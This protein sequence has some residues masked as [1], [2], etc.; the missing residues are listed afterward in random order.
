M[1]V[2]VLVPVPGPA[3]DPSSRCAVLE[4][5]M[6]HG[7]CLTIC[8]C[9]RFACLY[10]PLEPA[11]PPSA[12]GELCS[13]FLHHLFT[14]LNSMLTELVASLEVGCSGS[15]CGIGNPGLAARRGSCMAAGGMHHRRA[16]SMHRHLANTTCSSYCRGLGGSWPA[17]TTSMHAHIRATRLPP[18]AAGPGQQ[19]DAR[20][21]RPLPPAAAP[22][23]L[24]R[25]LHP[26]PAAHPGAHGR[27]A[28]AG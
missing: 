23:H 11:T 2:P 21:R 19:L 10:A 7:G 24:Y 4:S 3:P 5:C 26:G 14:H 18:P 27:Q 8:R 17:C 28:R 1:P 20:R 6:A 15:G 22:A 25:R 13:R 12:D 9:L 16:L